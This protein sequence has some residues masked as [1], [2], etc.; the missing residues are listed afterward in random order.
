MTNATPRV[1]NGT[2]ER[3]LF[4]KHQRQVT[5]L[6]ERIRALHSKGTIRGTGDAVFS[7]RVL[8]G[9]ERS[10]DRAFARPE[11]VQRWREV[12][13][14]SAVGKTADN[15]WTDGEVNNATRPRRRKKLTIGEC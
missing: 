2:F 9:R 6:E 5:G 3:L 12:L 13:A 10:T 7:R 8:F 1:R 4:P 15:G 14:N 11:I